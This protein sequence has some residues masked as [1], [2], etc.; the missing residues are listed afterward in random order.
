MHREKFPCLYDSKKIYG[1]WQKSN[2]SIWRIFNDVHNEL[3]ALCI[4]IIPIKYLIYKSNS[5]LQNSDVLMIEEVQRTQYSQIKFYID[6]FREQIIY[7]GDRQQCLNSRKGEEESNKHIFEK[8]IF[9]N[10]EYIK[11]SEKIRNNAE[12]SSFIK[13]LYN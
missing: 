12:I 4:D 1:T 7:C 6:N 13:H 11:L 5:I 3:N 2:N 9:R 10:F 8:L